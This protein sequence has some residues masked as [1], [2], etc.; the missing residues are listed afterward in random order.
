LSKTA[1][2]LLARSPDA[3]GNGPLSFIAP[4]PRASPPLRR[5]REIRSR[6]SAGPDYEV[7][8]RLSPSPARA[9]ALAE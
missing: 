1:R 9:D 2:I 8:E 5:V 6:A 3:R 4:S 7:L